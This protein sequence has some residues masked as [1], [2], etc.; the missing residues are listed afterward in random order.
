MAALGKGSGC[1][2]C[3]G[4]HFQREC[5]YK[6]KGKGKVGW[7]GDWGYGKA[8]WLKGS[9][10]GGMKGLVTG[11]MVKGGFDKGKGKGFGA[12]ADNEVKGG[13]GKGVGLEGGW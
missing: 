13:I 3:G 2:I 12:K 11:G 4:N 6:G 7:K 5:P 8:D 9:S 1:F 10:K